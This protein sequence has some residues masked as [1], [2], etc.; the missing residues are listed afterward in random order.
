MTHKWSS[1]D[2]F[3]TIFGHF[4]ANYTKIFH[5]KEIQTVILRYLVC[6]NLNGIK[7]YDIILVKRFFFMPE[8]ALYQGYFAEVGFGTS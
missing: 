4:L 1:W 3:W 6:L 2:H 8:N 5:K 7:S